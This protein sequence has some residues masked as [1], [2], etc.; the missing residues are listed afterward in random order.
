MK[1]KLAVLLSLVLVCSAGSLQAKKAKGSKNL[2]TDGDGKVSLAE[3]VVGKKDK[4]KAEKAFTKLDKNH[5]GFL[6]K[7]EL[8]AA[9]KKKK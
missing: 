7:E 4:A 1:T 5:D 9:K 3:F 6:S 8:E 2:D